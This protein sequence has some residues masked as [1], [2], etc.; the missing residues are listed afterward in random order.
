ML[1]HKGDSKVG[2]IINKPNRTRLQ[3]GE[4]VI[5]GSLVIKSHYVI[6]P[7]FSKSYLEIWLNV[8]ESEIDQSPH[9]LEIG[10]EMMRMRVV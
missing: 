7:P 4:I 9:C 3:G 1:P 5:T 10:L 2:I 6:S 8:V